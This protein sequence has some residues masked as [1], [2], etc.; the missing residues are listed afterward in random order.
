MGTDRQ[1]CL[2]PFGLFGLAI[3]PPR[4]PESKSFLISRF[5]SYTQ[6]TKAAL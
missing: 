2:Y 6:Q 4:V 3:D 1:V 5:A